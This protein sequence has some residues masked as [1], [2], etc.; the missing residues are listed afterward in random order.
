[1]NKSIGYE[2]I[3]QYD[4]QQRQTLAT[5]PE[6]NSAQYVYDANHNTIQIIQVSKPGSA[7]PN[8]VESFTYEPNFNR[9]ETHTDPND[10]VTIFSYYP[11]GKLQQ[12]GQPQ[13]DGNT[14]QTHFAY[15]SYGRVETITDAEGTVTK[16]EYGA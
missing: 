7:E 6:E 12:I 5:Y 15:N 14:P 16:Y 4:G 13:I 3:Y 9:I 1:L 11:N 2:T 10:N 8:I